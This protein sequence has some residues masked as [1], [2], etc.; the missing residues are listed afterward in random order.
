VTWPRLELLSAAASRRDGHLCAEALIKLEVH[1]EPPVHRATVYRTSE[2]LTKAGVLGH[3][4]LITL[5][6]VGAQRP[7]TPGIV[8][9][10][11]LVAWTAG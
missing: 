10:G 3:V 5:C 8:S 11:S 9:G 7:P 2:G 4:Q 1:A 6:T